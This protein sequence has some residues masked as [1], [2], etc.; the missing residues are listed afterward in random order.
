MHR[1]VGQ[2]A[3]NAQ[4]KIKNSGKTHAHK[5]QAAVAMEQ[6]AKE[7]GKSSEAAIYRRYIEQMK[8]KILKA[9]EIPSETP[10]ASGIYLT[11][12]LMNDQVG[13]RLIS[14]AESVTEI[15]ML[16]H[17]T[18]SERFVRL[19]LGRIM[20]IKTGQEIKDDNGSK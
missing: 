9:Q 13:Q 6:R 14:K 3:S 8:K 5:I 15:L 20:E 11:R 1:T 18:C 2:W 12:Q 7:M 10:D 4:I 16:P 19:S 17:T